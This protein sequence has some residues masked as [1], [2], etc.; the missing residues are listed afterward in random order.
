MGAAL[1]A[2]GA[3]AELPSSWNTWGREWGKVQGEAPGGRGASIGAA[4]RA[5]RMRQPPPHSGIGSHGDRAGAC[6]STRPAAAHASPA[7]LPISA[8]RG[9]A[10]RRGATAAAHLL[11]LGLLQHD[12]GHRGRRGQ[13]HSSR[14]AACGS[15]NI[16]CGVPGGSIWAFCLTD[17]PLLQKETRR[18]PNR[19][20]FAA[21]HRI[22]PALAMPPE[23]GHEGP[24]AGHGP[25]PVINPLTLLLSRADAHGPR[26][27][28]PR[29]A[30]SGPLRQLHFSAC[31]FLFLNE[32]MPVFCV[33]NEGCKPKGAA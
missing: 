9:S 7:S 19:H 28:G 1:A 24:I 12:T 10:A 30:G 13:Q 26:P 8:R 33:T 21:R 22:S 14:D 15:S 23:P 27:A 18:L 3:A 29:A 25:G 4:P 11:Q 2:A 31:A 32:G 16:A 20:L 5:C 17:R 6:R